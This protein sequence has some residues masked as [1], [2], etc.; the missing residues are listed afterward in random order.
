MATVFFVTSCGSTKENSSKKMKINTVKNT[1]DA[2]GTVKSS[3]IENIVID[4]PAGTDVSVISFYVREGQK[5]KK[6]DKL[7]KIDLSNLDALINQ[8]KKTI[9]ADKLLKNDM[10]TDNQ[11]KAQDYKIDAEQSEL[12]AI[13]GLLNKTYIKDDCIIS[14][15]DNAVVTGIGYKQGDILNA[16]QSVLC[17]QDLSSLYVQA[18]VDEEFIKDVTEGKT[19]S[20]V[21]ATDNT[22]ELSGKVTRIFNEAITKNGETSV[23]VEISLNNKGNLMPNYNVDV[24]I[25]K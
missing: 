2:V 14:D 16:Q 20:I 6:G 23:P 12:D 19:V 18:D 1:V 25:N 13:T 17:I 7:A 10:V 22:A 4:M 3:N 24:E 8:K 15:M 5:V 9:D 11:K 21:P